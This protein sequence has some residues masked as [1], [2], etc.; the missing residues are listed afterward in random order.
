M[1]AVYTSEGSFIFKFGLSTDQTTQNPSD[2]LS[3][4][5]VNMK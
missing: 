3:S 5:P 4:K 2:A 1:L